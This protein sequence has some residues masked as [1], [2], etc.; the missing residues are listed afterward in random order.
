MMN[1]NK[2][3]NW[4]VRLFFVICFI[5]F[6][7][8]YSLYVSSNVIQIT[9]VNLKNDKIKLP[10]KI[11]Q[12]SDLHGKYFGNN[13]EKLY[14]LVKNEE[15]DVIFVTGDIINF[16]DENMK[17]FSQK[18]LLI[19]NEN[20]RYTLSVLKQFSLIAPTYFVLGNH[21]HVF[22]KFDGGFVNFKNVVSSTGSIL[23]VN[24]I[25]SCYIN[26]NVVDIFGVDNSYY[27]DTKIH[28]MMVDFEKS[29]SIKIV[30]DHYPFNFALNG[31]FSYINH[32]V[33]YIFSGHE[34]G[35][36]IR[37]PFIGSLYSH[38]EGLF[39]KYAEGVHLQN[40]VTLIISR[41]LGNST[42]P[43]RIFN[44]PEIIVANIER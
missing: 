8:L 11:V 41:G 16:S 38:Q 12:I 23:L 14:S 34:H 39:P 28:S 35:G 18:D 17:S 13:N 7:L 20:L 30:L 40:G 37:I 3:F 27:Q 32:D 29:K 25:A 21:E 36:Q 24:E 15:P 43:I 9:R 22:E 2:K 6:I 5:A 10:I 26:R 1:K 19:Y 42:F 4:I 31:H 44:Q 33:D